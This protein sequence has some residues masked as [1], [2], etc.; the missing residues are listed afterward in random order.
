M[1]GGVAVMEGNAERRQSSE[2][3]RWESERGWTLCT[4][5]LIANDLSIYQIVGKFAYWYDRLLR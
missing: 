2:R 1:Q 5:M 3:K 4:S